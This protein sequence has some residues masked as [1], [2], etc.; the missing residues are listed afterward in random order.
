MQE[1]QVSNY[2]MK[3][4]KG[5]FRPK[6]RIHHKHPVGRQIC[7]PDQFVFLIDENNVNCGQVTLQAAMDKA[8]GVGLDVVQVS[9]SGKIP[10]TKILDFGKFKYDLSK[11]EKAAKKKQRES[12]IRIKEIKLRPST[13]INDLQVKA[14]KAKE[15]LED[16]DHVK[17][18]VIFK[19][20]EITHKDK[21][22]E[23]L[24]TFVELVEI[25][26]FMS[27]PSMQGRNITVILVKKKVKND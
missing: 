13:D 1:Q 6:N 4:H 23:I 24:N 3:K 25:G 22:M 5:N 27:V 12:S 26:E 10:T 18:C 16:G 11:K 17:L 7:R 2:F 8:N 20:R 21:G 19:G 9:K 14:K 15:F